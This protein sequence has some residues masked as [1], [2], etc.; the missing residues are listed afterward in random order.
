LRFLT[1]RFKKGLSDWFTP[2]VEFSMRLPLIFLSIFF[3]AFASAQDLDLN[4]AA[5]DNIGRLESEDGDEVREANNQLGRLGSIEFPISF[6]KVGTATVGLYTRSGRLVRILAQVIPVEA[7]EYRLRWDGLDLFGNPVAAGTELD[8]KIIFSPGIKATYEMA[9]SAPK[10][11]PWFGDFT[12]NGQSRAGGWMGDHS[13]PNSIAFAGDRL[14]LGTMLAEEGDNLAAISLDGEKIWG[15]KLEGWDGPHQISSDGKNVA[16]LNR[17]R[18]TVYRMPVEMTSDNRGRKSLAKQNVFSSNDIQHIAVHGDTLLAVTSNPVTRVNPF[19]TAFGNGTIDFTRSRPQ[20]SDTSAPTEFMIS[21]QAG[22]ANTFTSAGN[23]QNGAHM[24]PHEGV[25]YLLLVL[26]KDVDVGTVLLPAVDDAAKIEVFTLESGTEYEDSHSPF[27]SKGGALDMSLDEQGEHWVLFGSSPAKAPLNWLPA[28][29]SPVKTR[30]LLFKATPRGQAPNNWRPFL[31][32]ARI[33][34][35]RI[36]EKGAKP[37]SVTA[38]TGVKQSRTLGTSGWTVRSEYPISSVYPLHMVLDY[39]KEQTFNA[40]AVYNATH[41]ELKVDVLRKGVDPKTASETDWSEVAVIKGGF[42]KKLGALTASRHYFERMASLREEQ[43]T[44]ALRFRMVQGYQKGKW[45]DGKDDSFLGE[46]QHVALLHI[47]RPDSAAPS[48]ELH[49]VDFQKGELRKSWTGVGSD[50]DA[51]DFSPDGVLYSIANGRLNRTEWNK[52]TGTLSHVPVGDLRFESTDP[53]SMDVSADRIAVGDRGKSII[54]VMDRQGRL[55]HKIGTGSGREPGPWNPNVIARPSAVA[56]TP[57]GELWVAEETF[58]PKRVARFGRD[59]S[60]IDEFLGPPMYGGGGHLDPDLKQF[61][62]RGMEFELD[63]KAG[64][65][66]LKNLNDRAY[67][68]NTPDDGTSTFGFTSIGRPVHHNGQRYLHS[69]LILVRKP[70]DS[71]TWKPAFVAGYAHENPFLLRKD[72]WNKHWGKFDL[73]DKFFVWNDLNGDGQYQVEEVEMVQS[74]TLPRMGGGTLGPGLSLWGSTYRWA[75]ASFTP[76]GVP[77]FKLADIQPFSYDALA[78]HYRENYT[79]S[80]PRSAKPGYGGMRYVSSTGNLAQEGQPF[81]VKA[82]GTILGGP[83]DS[84]PSEYR[85]PI[86][87]QVVQTAWS[88]TGGAMTDSDIGEIAIINSFKGAWHVWAVDY[89]VMVGRFFT[90]EDGTWHGMEPVRGMDVTRR[91]FGWEGW[92]GDFLRANDGNYYAQGGKSFHAIAKIDGLND[93]KVITRPHRVTPDEAKQAL[94][95]RD[96]LLGRAKANRGLSASAR[97]QKQR[98]R[99]FTLDGLLDDWGDRGAFTFIDEARSTRFALSYNDQG[100]LVAF[101]GSGDVKSDVKDW[102]KAFQEGFALELHVRGPGKNQSGGEPSAG[103]K[104]IVVIR[105]QG[106]WRAVL[107]QP[108]RPE[109]AGKDAWTLKSPNLDL[110]LDEVR[111]LSPEE[112]AIHMRDKALDINLTDLDLGSAGGFGDDLMGDKIKEEQKASK[113]NDWSAE[114]LIPWKLIGAGEGA[115]RMDVGFRRPSG[116]T[117]YWNNAYPG[118]INDPALLLHPNPAAW[119]SVTFEED[120]R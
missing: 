106:K 49:W 8:L 24:V 5:G 70:D 47:P 23:R 80:G 28:A 86:V 110:F 104:R 69:G 55:L 7:R 43:T 50:I 35:E 79:L 59:G 81:V 113:G 90:A 27:S 102:R 42:A 11:A 111:L 98:L 17:K 4:R 117:F 71:P 58:A 19:R 6:D 12:R 75:P 76:A 109:G 88:W 9:V 40:M 18:N 22:F 114:I 15:S 101:D 37:L 44:R 116:E 61:F 48:H 26:N 74:A 97:P 57:A 118:P 41:P 99:N 25:A 14:L 82:D 89:G 93:F 83:V 1:K 13:A 39:G 85:P 105:H 108:L 94:A 10:V 56:L 46:N 107:Y 67:H 30:A 16:V 115:R 100:I 65:S 91:Y 68:P 120:K 66:R 60:F 51:M 119:G 20:V 95:L 36:E 53:Y 92:H 87:G 72:V 103:D 64:T 45:G 73:S 21:P 3:V 54:F 77:V 32:L 2:F 31:G 33:F 96:V 38:V 78:P 63:W 62:Y 112:L 84:K 34:A 52:D 29:T